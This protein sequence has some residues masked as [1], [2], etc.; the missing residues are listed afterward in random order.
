MNFMVGGDPG[1]LDR[2]R[3]LLACLGPVVTHVGPVGSGHAIKAINM[4]ALA[5][6]MLATAEVLDAG[7]RCGLAPSSTVE[8]FEAGRGGSY[9]TRVHFPRFVLPGTFDSGFSF[10]L[11][12]K[13]LSIATA[14]AARY[15]FDPWMGARAYEI[16]RVAK[17]SG[18]A[19]EDNTRIVEM[20]P[21]PRPPRAP[22]AGWQRLLD[23]LDGLAEAANAAI[24]AETLLLGV[25]AG[26]APA[27][28][29]DVVT[30]SSG[31]S[32]V[33]ETDMRHNVLAGTFDSGATIG[34]LRIRAARALARA[35]VDG[36]PMILG[37]SAVALLTLAEA[38]FGAEADR[39]RFV[40]LLAQRTGTRLLQQ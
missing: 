10:D 36:V 24:A 20:R 3:P 30:A 31:T 28:V 39:T 21:S 37:A 12:Y 17:R 40:Q 34:E 26:L 16:Y 6:S 35:V 32:T 13:D 14:L 11:M 23:E 29:V 27:T 4:L 25:R 33:L 15:E 9:S 19:G 1:V 2:W 38:A 18:L 22:V 8:A 5:G 7:C